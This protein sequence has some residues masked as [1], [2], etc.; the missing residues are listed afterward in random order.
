MTDQEIAKKIFPKEVKKELDKIAHE[1][2]K[3]RANKP[4]QS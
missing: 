2:D 3:K 4:S 1:T